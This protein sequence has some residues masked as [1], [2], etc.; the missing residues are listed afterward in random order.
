MEY[1]QSKFIIDHVA[2]VVVVADP[3]D[4]NAPTPCHGRLMWALLNIENYY[5]DL[6]SGSNAHHMLW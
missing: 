5:P 1:E 2:V 6:E 4:N 3:V